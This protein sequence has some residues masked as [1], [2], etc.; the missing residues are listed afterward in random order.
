MR[1]LILM[2]LFGTD[3]IEDY[4]KLLTQRINHLKEGLELIHAHQ[5]TLEREEWALNT[6]RKL[7]KVCE[8]HGIDIDEAIKHIQLDNNEKD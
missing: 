3:D 5:R 1:K 8:N 6:L 7:I 4:M 2:W